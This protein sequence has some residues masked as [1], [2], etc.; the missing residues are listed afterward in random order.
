MVRF[1]DIIDKQAQRLE[2]LVS[3]LLILSS[4]EF[5]EVKMNFMA[6]P[7][8]KIVHSVLAIQEDLLKIE[9]IR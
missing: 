6:E 1:L 5:K 7:L 4:I 2:N 9:G 3:D 8:N